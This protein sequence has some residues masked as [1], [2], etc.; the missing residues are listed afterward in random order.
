MKSYS[1]LE[2]RIALNYSLGEYNSVKFSYNRTRQ[3]IFMLSNTIA[4]SPT[5]QW[6]LA[7]YHIKPPVSDQVSLGYYHDFPNLG[8]IT[9][10]EVYQKWTKNVVEYK[11]GVD[12]ISPDPIEMSILQGTQKS[13]GLELMLKKNT[14]KL[15]GWISY[16]YSRSMVQID[17]AISTEQINYGKAFPSSYDRPH[18]INFVSNLRANRRLSLSTNVIY[19]TGRPITYPVASYESESQKI[20]YFSER[21]QYRMPDYFRVDFSIN[22]EGNLLSK[23]WIHSYWMINVYNLTGRK[24]AYSIYYESKDSMMQGYKLSVFGQPIVTL[25]WNFKFGNYVSE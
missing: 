11:D 15:T 20:L 19:S 17:N 16:C 6:K 25:S 9:S 21:N 14:G 13:Y 4:I 22:L 12:F 5:D 24:N 1:G 18:S 3:Y 2:P 10:T 7:D 23:K 8:L